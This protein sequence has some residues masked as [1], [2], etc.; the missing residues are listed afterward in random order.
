MALIAIAV[1]PQVLPTAAIPSVLDMLPVGI[2]GMM[3]V[4]LL[5]IIM[6]TADSYLNVASII[7]LILNFLGV[8]GPVVVVPLFVGIFGFQASVKSFVLSA[9]TGFIIF[10]LWVFLRI[11]RG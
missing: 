10:L 9:A 2:K 8:W 1:N 7:D 4:C 5:A 3:L 6:S 11:V